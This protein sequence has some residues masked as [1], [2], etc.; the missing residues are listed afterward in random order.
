MS[1]TWLILSLIA[2]GILIYG[3][4]WV[5]KQITTQPRDNGLDRYR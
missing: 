2:L 5:V 4:R 1:T 3:C